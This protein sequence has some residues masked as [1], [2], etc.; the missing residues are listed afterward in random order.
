MFARL[1]VLF[2]TLVLGSS[3]FA[4]VDVEK[5]AGLPRYEEV[6]ISPT[7]ER[8]AYIGTTEGVRFAVVFDLAT[9][10]LVITKELSNL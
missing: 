9:G 8:L 6:A 7:G 4:E 3:A 1:A 10:D 5:Y 2:V